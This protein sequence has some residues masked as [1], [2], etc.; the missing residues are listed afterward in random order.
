MPVS[1]QQPLH[2]SSYLV[3]VYKSDCSIVS[4]V[5]GKSLQRE[6]EL[7]ESLKEKWAGVGGYWEVCTQGRFIMLEQK[8]NRSISINGWKISDEL[9]CCCCNFQAITSVSS[10]SRNRGC[11][12]GS[13]CLKVVTGSFSESDWNMHIGTVN[14]SWWTLLF[15][16]NA[17]GK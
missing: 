7:P 6:S 1:L 3:T 13:I 17:Q 4:P 9:S 5:Q 15:V 11:S 16:C 2:V 14:S 12:A 10:C 8:K